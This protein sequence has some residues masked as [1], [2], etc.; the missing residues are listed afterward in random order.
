MLLRPRLARV[1]LSAPTRALSAPAAP[2]SALSPAPAWRPSG[3]RVAARLA[4]ISL[5][6][7]V[8]Y[9]RMLRGV[10]IERRARKMREAFVRLGPAFVKV[11]QALATRAEVPPLLAAELAKLQD[12]MA[13]FDEA[14]ARAT[15]RRELGVARL[16]EVFATL[17]AA[18]VS[19]A[20]LGQVYVGTLRAGAASGVAAGT[21]V[22]V[23]VQRPGLER[24]VALD[25]R[26]VRLLMVLAQGALR[27]ARG[28]GAAPRTDLAGV[29]DEVVGLI[30]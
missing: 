1:A 24:Q 23:K 27:V 13:P 5:E 4:R 6:L 25:A 8:I 11:G 28:P 16:D 10:P 14:A 15:L 19:A 2:S 26:A 22:A 20:S 9:A 3:A 30:A 12:E 7:A 29:A 17:S 18:P 21:R